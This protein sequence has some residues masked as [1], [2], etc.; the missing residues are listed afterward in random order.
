MHIDDLYRRAAV[1]GGVGVWDWNLVTDEIYVDPFI[2]EILG[3]TDYE[4]RDHMDD[5]GRLLHPDDAGSVFEQIQAHLRGETPSFDSEYQLRHRDGSYRWFHSRGSAVRNEHG[6]AVRL[7]GTVIDVTERR[8]SEEALRHAQELNR[9][10][11]DST[12]DCVKILDLEGRLQY[13]NPVALRLLGVPDASGLLNRS[14]SEFLTGDE[15]R[16]AEAAVA[17]ARGGGSGRFQYSMRMAA[18]PKSFDAVVTPITDVNGAVVQL[19]AISR[20]ITERR[21]EDAFRAAQHQ[22]LEM[23]ATGTPSPAVLDSLVR[24]VESQSDGMLCTVLLLDEDGTTVRHGAAPSMPADYVQGINGLAIGP[25]TGSCGTAMYLGQRVIVTDVLTDPLWENFRD[26]AQ[27]FG[28]RACWST[29]IFSPQRTVLGSFAMYYT[30]PREPRDDE[31]RLIETAA[32]IARIAIEQQ[33][34]SQALHRSEARVQAILRAIPDWMFLTTVDGLFLDYHAKDASK[35]HVPPS[36]FLNKNIRDV[37]PPPVAEALMQ[38][39]A[40]ANGSDEAEK[41][42]YTLGSEGAERFYEACIV[43]CDGDKILSIVR[44]ITG[45]KL[46]ELE[47]DAQRRQLAHLSRVATLGELSGAL[48]HELSQPLTAVLTNAQAARHFLDRTPLDV[49]QVRAALD[50]IIRNDKR[51]GTVIDRLRAML[52]GGETARQ[53]VDLSEVVREVIDLAY[54]ELTSRRVT[55]KSAL[56]PTIPPVLGDR[57]QLQ[58]VVLN[59]VLNACDAMN[60]T[61]TSVRQLVLSTTADDGF[62]ELAVSDRG[63]G[64]PDGQLERV[65]EPFVTFR[66]DGLGLGLSISRSIVTAH[67]GSIRAENNADGGATFRCLLPVASAEAFKQAV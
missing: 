66:E 10:I 62:V 17:E 54:G 18:G 1:A 33:R 59:L 47:S 25:R 20:D 11:V 40:R 16:A 31:L 23:I 14:L 36:A 9:R 60:A 12:G 67:G 42:E 13:L 56:T 4:V 35:L 8:H 30:E 45:R 57:V 28:F 19:L 48:A 2:K 29:P 22:V 51:A 3:F 38:G 6:T 5:W 21:R 61:H 7:S 15:R 46:A 26:V 39:F 65:F 53:P 52:R 34:A 37:L 55:V 32:D 44:D 43:R 41:V 64:I 50:D 49:E 27:R 58:Q 63:P 24:L